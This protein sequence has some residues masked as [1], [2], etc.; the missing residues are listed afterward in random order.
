MRYPV[1]DAFATELM[2]ALYDKLLDKRRPLPAALHLA[3]DDALA[4]DIP[5]PPMAPATPI[6]VGVRAAEL[7][8]AP[9]PQESQTF[10]LPTVELRI[11][12]PA[13]PERFVDRLQPMLRA[14]QALAKGSAKR[15][16]LFHGTPG[17]GKTACALE[18]AYRHE[19]GRFQGYVWHRAPEA[20]S[21]ISSALFNLMQDI[22]TQLNAPDLGLTTA[23]ADPQHFRQ[24]ALPRL[25]ALLQGARCCWCWTTWKRC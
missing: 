9:P 25:R 5:K 21:D 20:G 1:D 23:L 15:S 6:L 3:L 10:A 11:A 8:L 24:F 4:A 14:S 7:Q 19:H 18:L 16:V 13:E 2:L 12:F 17:A 22:Q